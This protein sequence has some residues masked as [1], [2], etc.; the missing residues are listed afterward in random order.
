M[1]LLNGREGRE[2]DHTMAT[3]IDIFIHREGHADPIH[4]QDHDGLTVEALKVHLE[5][6]GEPI[7]FFLFEEDADEP[8]HDHH[9][10]RHRGEGTRFL[11]HSR[12][13]HVRVTVRYAGKP[14]VEHDFGPG[15]T[16]ARIKRWAE[17]K[18]GIDEA[19]AAEMSLQV[20]GTRDRPDES[21][22]VGSLVRHPDCGVTFDLLPSDRVNGAR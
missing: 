1:T 6:G 14:P 13:R 10:I 9:E 17:R 16:L 4:H 8:L 21:T 15:S 2:G 19:D 5:G 12:C 20:A 18:L 22:H 7:D 11:H 3:E